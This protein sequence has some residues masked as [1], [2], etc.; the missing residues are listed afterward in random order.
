VLPV[1]HNVPESE[2]NHRSKFSGFSDLGRM[3][4]SMR[5]NNETNCLPVTVLGLGISL[6]AEDMGKATEI[7]GWLCNNKCVRR[8][9]AMRPVI[10]TVQT[11][12][13]ML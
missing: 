12:A 11:K 2:S 5:R 6:F 7:T 13:E 10:R 4:F 3:E 1:V 9:R 8:P